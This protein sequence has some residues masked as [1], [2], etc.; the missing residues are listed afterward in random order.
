MTDNTAPS[1]DTPRLAEA[2]ER[3]GRDAID[4]LPFGAI[5]LNREGQVDLFSA[6]EARLSG[7]DQAKALGATFFTGV[8]PCFA[9]AG[10]ME[11]IERARSSGRIDIEFEH[12]G[13][14]NDAE[15]E[16]RCRIQSAADGGLWIFLQRL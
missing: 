12:V 15:K 16:L 14:F 6:S 1:F 4:S 5:H 9:K 10:F 8:A 11:R 3:L 2:V 13:D 7:F